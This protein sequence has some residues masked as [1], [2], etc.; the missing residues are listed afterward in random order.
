MLYVLLLLK[1]YYFHYLYYNLLYQLF[2]IICIILFVVNYYNYSTVL[3]CII[4]IIAIIISCVDRFA[5]EAF[6]VRYWGCY[7]ECIRKH[8][9]QLLRQKYCQSPVMCA[10]PFRP[11]T[12]P[13]GAQH[14][15]CPSAGRA[16]VRLRAAYSVQSLSYR[17]TAG[18]SK[19]QWYWTCISDGGRLQTWWISVLTWNLSPCHTS[20]RTVAQSTPLPFITYH[21]TIP[22]P[23]SWQT[24]SRI[25][26]RLPAGGRRVRPD[27]RFAG[28][29]E[30]FLCLQQ[31][32]P[33]VFP[34][35][36]EWGWHREQVSCNQAHI[37]LESPQIPANLKRII[38]II[39]I[40]AII[41]D[42][43]L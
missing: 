19:W 38:S 40:I 7:P 11:R 1:H 18:R 24:T 12:P 43:P 29:T 3:I 21:G 35:C 30:W 28:G 22:M 42:K 14:R 6:G 34:E 27:R 17:C 9:R 10:L 36:F 4:D 37:V 26:R 25:R 13:N 8:N 39:A 20:C 33:Q 5:K 31:A 32:Q 16:Q 23:T 15:L 41:S 2:C